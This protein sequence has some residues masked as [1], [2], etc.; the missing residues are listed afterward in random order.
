MENNTY[1][2]PPQNVFVQLSSCYWCA[3][4]FGVVLKKKNPSPFL[5]SFLFFMHIKCVRNLFIRTHVLFTSL[6]YSCQLGLGE[7]IPSAASV[8]SNE[9]SRFGPLSV[10][11]FSNQLSF[12]AK[13]AKRY[14]CVY[15]I[16]KCF[17]VHYE[18]RFVRNR[19][20]VE[21]C[22]L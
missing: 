8:A 21:R 14:Q 19:V 13:F 4:S 3:Q 11:A 15:I 22:K 18:N 5:N 20:L 2:K 12:S 17:T 9:V 1:T 10:F 6:V 16:L 7:L